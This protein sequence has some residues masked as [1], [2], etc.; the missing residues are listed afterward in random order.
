MEEK[1]IQE[2]DVASMYMNSLPF[3][4]LPDFN[5]TNLFKMTNKH[6][7]TYERVAVKDGNITNVKWICLCSREL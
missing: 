1:E 2:G 7:H 5:A 4:P 3:K 6:K